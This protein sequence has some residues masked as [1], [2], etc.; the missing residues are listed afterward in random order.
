MKKKLSQ[1][2]YRL[3]KMYDKGDEIEVD[4]EKALFWY[5]KAADNGNT[6]AMLSLGFMYYKGDGIEVNSELAEEYYHQA[7]I[8]CSTEAE[9]GD[10]EA[11]YNLALTYDGQGVDNKEKA[12]Y[13]YTK[14]AEEGDI[15]AQLTLAHMYDQGQGVEVDKEKALDLYTQVAERGYF[16]AQ[17]ELA[18]M[19]DQGDGVEVN[20]EIAAY[21]YSEVKKAVEE[22]LADR[23]YYLARKYA[24]GD[25]V[26]V[27]KRKALYW[28]TKAAEQGHIY[29]Q[30]EL[31][32]MYDQGDG[33]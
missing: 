28:F 20:N 16:S 12:L 8:A 3:A 19:Y 17:L 14:A 2:Q 27:D 13:W 32:Y 33:V 10:R 4:K 15:P 11:Q 21:W 9:K 22:E 31:A 26:E 24:L 6:N 18:Y 30:L 1:T 7:F 23:E 29:A 5:K 25:E